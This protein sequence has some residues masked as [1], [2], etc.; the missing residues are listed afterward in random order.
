MKKIFSI[1]V[2]LMAMVCPLH[3]EI[4][5]TIGADVVSR[6]IWR[7]CDLGDASLQPSLGVGAGGFELSLWGSTG[8]VRAADTKEL[9]ITI[10]YG[11]AGL[12]VGVADYWFNVGPEPH[13]RYFK[14]EEETTNHVFE[15]FVGYDFGFASL[16]WYTNFAGN[17]FKDD[18]DRAFSS[19]FEAAA[20]FSAGGLDWTAAIGVVPFGTPFYGTDGF[21]V[22]NLTLTASKELGITDSFSLPVSAGLTV[23]PSS[24][25]A[26]FVFGISF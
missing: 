18:G 17:D 21:A 4:E 22:T 13:G 11:I 24:E 7:G 19:Y 2:L 9:D 1:T 8:I 23:N 6:Y 5:T 25:M 20:P 10:S 26:Y 15:A 16:S 3:A 12:S 14:Y